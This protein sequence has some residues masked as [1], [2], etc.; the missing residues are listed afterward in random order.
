MGALF[1]LPAVPGTADEL[2]AWASRHGVELWASDANG[3]PLD[4]I[5]LRAPDAP[6]LCLLVGN[7]GAGVSP[8]LAA[9]AAR[10]VA[11]PLRTGAESLNVAVAAGI[12]LY[13][14]LRER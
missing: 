12:I 4:R 5:T 2:L 3:T 1:R 7:E 10:R 8:A 13:E 9:R 11:I 6:P 14:V